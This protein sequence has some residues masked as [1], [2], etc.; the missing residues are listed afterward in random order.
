MTP[1]LAQVGKRFSTFF[2]VPINPYFNDRMKH[3]I[4]K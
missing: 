1:K 4:N 3:P 2:T